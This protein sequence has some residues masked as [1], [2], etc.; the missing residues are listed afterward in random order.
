MDRRKRASDAYR[1]ETSRSSNGPQKADT[2]PDAPEQSDESSAAKR[3]GF[4]KTVS[5]GSTAES[6]PREEKTEEVTLES[7]QAAPAKQDLS[8]LFGRSGG[9]DRAARLLISMGSDRAARVLSE[10][11]EAEVEQVTQA[12][13]KTE[14][15]SR[16]EVSEAGA[17]REGPISAGPEVARQML[18]AAFGE[19]EGERRFFV[20]VPNAPEHHFAFLNEFEPGQVQAALR[21]ESPGVLALVI[22]HIDPKLAASVFNELPKD[23]QAGI[24]RRIARM[25]K[26]SRS[27]VVQVEAALR[28]KIRTIGTQ[29]TDEK[30]GTAQLAAIVRHLPLTEAET[31]IDDLMNVDPQMADD[32]R[33]ELVTT[34]VLERL[35][36]RDLADLLREFDER[37]IAMLLKGKREELRA[38]V[39]RAVSERRATDISEAFAHLGAQR[40]EDVDRVTQEV[41][42][43]LQERDR[44]GSLL[45]PREGDRYI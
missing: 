25:G 20:S 13:I 14:R 36:P 27:T 8:E 39:L 4:G 9:I 26:L 18:I 17:D 40:R 12:I 7:S 37:E 42:D 34:E 24:A 5:D 43:R 44:E 11:S 21:N 10:L 15:F 38:A 2:T 3:D 31:L 22:A 16:N 19:D 35:A 29:Q 30:G 33:R 45:V 41:L 23:Q 32:L 28:E 6:R 1:S